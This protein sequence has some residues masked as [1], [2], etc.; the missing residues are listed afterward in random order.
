MGEGR[1]SPKVCSGGVNIHPSEHATE[2]YLHPASLFPPLKSVYLLRAITA[3]GKSVN[4]A[5]KNPPPAHEVAALCWPEN[6]QSCHFL[7]QSILSSL[8]SIISNP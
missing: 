4:H 8:T 6:R 2:K 3:A 5:G 7:A 1:R